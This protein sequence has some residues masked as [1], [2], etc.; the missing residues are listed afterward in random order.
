MQPHTHYIMVMYIY[1]YMQPHTH[2]VMVM[3]IYMYMQPHTHYVMAMYM[4]IKGS[5]DACTYTCTCI[6]TPLNVKE[7]ALYMNL[8]FYVTSTFSMQS[9][10]TPSANF[11]GSLAI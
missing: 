5:E 3:Y 6:L 2:Y 1:M 9:C 8:S 4:Y 11:L 7:R 10:N